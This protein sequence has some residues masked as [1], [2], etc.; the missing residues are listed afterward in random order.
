MALCSALSVSG[1]FLSVLAGC[2]PQTAA[3][4]RPTRVADAH[5]QTSATCQSCHAEIFAAWQPTDHANANRRI[6]ERDRAAFTIAQT[7]A[8]GGSRFDL[9][10]ENDHPKIIERR[11][12]AAGIP[13]EPDLVLGSKPLWQP[14]VPAPGGRW[15]PTEVAFDPARKE[16]F[17]VFGQENRQPGEWG[18]W[19]GRGMNW[20]SMCAHCHMTGFQKNY[21]AATDSYASTWVEHGVG[22]IQCHGA[23]PAVHNGKNAVRE[24]APAPFHGDRALMQQTCAPCHARNELLTADFQPG[25]S[26]HDHYRL[27][28]PTDAAVFYPDGQVRDEDFNW[29]SVQLSR[30]G[31]AGVTCLDCHDPHSTK[32]LLPSS[33]NQLC[34]QCHTAPGRVLASGARAVPIDQGARH[35]QRLQPLPHRQ[36]HRLGDRLR[37][38]VVWR[39]A[40]LASAA[41]R[42]SR[43][44]SASNAARCA[45]RRSGSFRQRGHSGMARHIARFARALRPHACGH[46]G[47]TEFAHGPRSAG[48]RRRRATAR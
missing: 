1:L 41:P 16:W 24:K 23:M 42:P 8:D 12:G 36:K 9:A 28:L 43:R 6:A 40:R 37:R 30:M 45:G 19:T 26:Y 32:T 44:G 3:A 25:D 22:C 14:L 34:L 33:N 21:T 17:N 4:K 39:Q 29:T 38:R 11:D 2:R 15:Q 35:S 5:A 10:W 20:N 18:H 47:R 27:V 7:I 31:H 46:R 48:T 13:H